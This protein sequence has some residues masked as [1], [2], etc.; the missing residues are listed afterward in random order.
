[1]AVNLIWS[2]VAQEDLKGVI[3][4][5][6]HENPVA[7]ENISRAIV[8]RTELLA[9]FPEMGRIVPERA[10]PQIREL[11]YQNY[12]IIYRLRPTGHILEIIRIW[13]GARGEPEVD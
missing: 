5:I 12:R 2:L 10:D 13:H 11:V 1:M 9:S 8:E 4:Y 7:A 3:D 6:R